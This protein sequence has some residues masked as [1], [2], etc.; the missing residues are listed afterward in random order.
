M[1]IKNKNKQIFKQIFKQ[2]I[3]QIFKYIIKPFKFFDISY[4]KIWKIPEKY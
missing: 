4:L 1:V 2:I 3:K